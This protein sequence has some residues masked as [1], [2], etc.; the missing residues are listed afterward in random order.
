VTA[1]S[2]SLTAAGLA[3][4]VLLVVQLAG[5]LRWSWLAELQANDLYKQLSGFALCAF[6]ACQWRLSLARAGGRAQGNSRLAN[7]HKRVG[8]AAPVLFFLHS[9]SLGYAYQVALS[10]TYLALF[11]SGVF[12][13]EALGIPNP[14]YRTAWIAAHVSLA[15]ALP[16]LLGYHVYI[17]YMFE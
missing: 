6:I 10:L 12:H 1:R 5:G 17:T 14:G 11:V 9:Q 13:R 4:L 3:L 8:L 2:D 7:T 15:T 16:I